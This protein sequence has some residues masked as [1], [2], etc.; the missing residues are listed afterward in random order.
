MTF[1]NDKESYSDLCEDRD[2]RAKT[3]SQWTLCFKQGNKLLDK[4][5]F[6]D[7]I[8]VSICTKTHNCKAWSGLTIKEIDTLR[9]SQL[10]VGN[11]NLKIH[12][13]HIIYSRCSFQNELFSLQTR[14]TFGEMLSWNYLF[15]IPV[16]IV[17]TSHNCA[18][19]LHQVSQF[20]AANVLSIE[21]KGLL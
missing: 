4:L 17:V 16:I 2:D 18:Y 12:N 8:Q 20:Y 19:L 5:K 9:T 13:L 21:Y 7:T 3:L 6:I 10:N 15:L 11:Y 14:K 1:L